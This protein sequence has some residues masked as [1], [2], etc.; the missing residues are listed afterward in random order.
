MTFNVDIE[1]TN[2][3]NASCT[4][5]PRDV[6][7]DQGL[8]SRDTFEQALARSRARHIRRSACALA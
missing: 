2:R 7:P 8:M 4:F 6:M 5:C 3:C 1:A